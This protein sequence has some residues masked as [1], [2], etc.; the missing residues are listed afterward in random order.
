MTHRALRVASLKHEMPL[1]HRRTAISFGLED[2]GDTFLTEWNGG[3]L[4]PGAVSFRIAKY[5]VVF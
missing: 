3:I 2:T 1:I 4:G 5:I